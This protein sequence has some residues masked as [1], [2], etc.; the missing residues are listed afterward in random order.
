[1]G[2]VAELKPLADI[3]VDYPPPGRATPE[4]DVYLYLSSLFLVSLVLYSLYITF[5]TSIHGL[6]VRPGAEEHDKV[7]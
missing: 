3:T 4:A 6:F 5:Q 1:M 2:F 7:E